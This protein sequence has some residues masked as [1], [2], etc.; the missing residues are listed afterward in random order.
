MTK[1]SGLNDA[2]RSCSAQ[3]QYGDRSGPCKFEGKYPDADGVRWWCGIHNPERNKARPVQ[4]SSSRVPK[5]VLVGMK[6]N[7]DQREEMLAALHEARMVLME[8]STVRDSGWP[9]NTP[10]DKY[11]IMM[12]HMADRAKEAA[13]E[14]SEKIAR[15]RS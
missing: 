7:D 1:S 5:D 3:V 2:A 6:P 14:L 11:R 13:H 4:D 8:L 15:F 9:P 10:I 12:A